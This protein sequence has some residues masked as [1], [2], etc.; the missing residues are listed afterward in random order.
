MLHAS[1]ISA[2]FIGGSLAAASVEGDRR[3]AHGFLHTP[4]PT[5]AG[6]A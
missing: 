2:C 4:F 5:A 1:A 3:P 6:L